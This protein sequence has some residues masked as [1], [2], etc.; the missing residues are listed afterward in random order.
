MKNNP[1]R[2]RGAR[3]RAEK[4]GRQALP[5]LQSST[6]VQEGAAVKAYGDGE[7]AMLAAED[8]QSGSAGGL[9][10]PFFREPRA[11]LRIAP[12]EGIF[13]G[14][15]AKDVMTEDPVCCTPDTPLA[16]VARLMAE[17]S[18]GA[19]PV[20]KSRED[21]IPM[22]LL[23]DRDIVIRTVAMGRNPLELRARDVDTPVVCTVEPE[24]PLE[25]CAQRM[26]EHKVRRLVVV[27]AGGRVRGMLA[28]AD[29]ARAL[30]DAAGR[31]VRDVSEPPPENMR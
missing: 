15:R 17:N 24:T 16:M 12:S 30:P 18:C 21:R 5:P 27:D 3:R 11:F 8:W 22:G 29:L 2:E 28:Q 14:M 1:G 10:R 6:P 26:R 13:T 20:V 31:M 9:E 23:T 4:R 7:P 25:E 19:V